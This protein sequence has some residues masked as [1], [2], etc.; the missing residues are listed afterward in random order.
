M[1]EMLPLPNN[2]VHVWQ[3]QVDSESLRECEILG[4]LSPDER[5]RAERFHFR[6]DRDLY[7]VGRS[8]MRTLL[9]GYLG[10]Q[11]REIRFCYSAHGKPELPTDSHTDLQFNLSHSQEL[12]LFAITRGRKIGVDIEFMRS[13]TVEGKLAERV[14]S[15]GELAAFNALPNEL[16]QRGFFNGWTR[17]EA[18]IKAVGGGLSLSLDRFDV[19]LHPAQPAKLLAIRSDPGELQ[20]WSLRDLELS[21]GYA[22]AIVVESQDWLLRRHAWPSP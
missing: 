3:A 5:S 12:A 21:D 9:G 1:I 22:G 14:F 8:M 19:S 2:E 20:R 13:S 18:F 7:V 11:P 4:A 17:K 10:C 16:K 15:S 6:R